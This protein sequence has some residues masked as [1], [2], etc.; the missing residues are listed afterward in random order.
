MN[1]GADSDTQKSGGHGRRPS[2]EQGPAPAKPLEAL[3]PVASLLLAATLWGLFWYPLRRFEAN[4][5]SGLWQSL[6]IYCGTLVAALPMLRGRWR[7][8]GRDPGALI[9]LA[10]AS[11]WCNTAFILAMLDGHVVRVL[12][13]FYLSPV[14]ATLLAVW[15]LGEHLT[16]VG[17]LVLILAMAGALIMLWTPGMGLPWPREVADWLALSSGFGF[18]LT[19]VMVRRMQVVSVRV[20]T[21]V[22]WVGVILMAGALIVIR[23]APLGDVASPVWLTALAFGAVVMVV[24]TLSVQYG[25]THMPVHRSAIIL[26]FEL[27]VGAVSAGLLTNETVQLHEWA[28]GIFIVGAAYL[29]SRHATRDDHEPH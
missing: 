18:A 19:N 21:V 8:L 13:L 27:V 20:K 14:W 1:T 15:L 23:G 6:F 28:G 17:V 26:L 4:G 25:V 12:L 7:E 3:W 5:L 22:A 10:A 24:M 9:V 11:G 16:R 29:S 2:I